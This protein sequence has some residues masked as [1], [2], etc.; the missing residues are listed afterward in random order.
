MDDELLLMLENYKLFSSKEK[1]VGDSD[2]DLDLA[3]DLD[4][5]IY[6]T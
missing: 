5:S 4:K 1:Y 6:C 3:S 2:D